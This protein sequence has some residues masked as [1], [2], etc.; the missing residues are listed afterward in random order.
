MELKRG[1]RADSKLL[2]QLEQQRNAAGERGGPKSGAL[3]TLTV[4]ARDLEATASMRVS[5]RVDEWPGMPWFAH[6]G[7]LEDRVECK[8]VILGLLLK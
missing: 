5:G 7:I 6:R 2:W 4:S 1:G 8:S 3:P